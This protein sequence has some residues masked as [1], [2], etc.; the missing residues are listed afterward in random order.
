MGSNRGNVADERI[1]LAHGGG[2]EL[3]KRLLAEHI[4]PK[5]GNDL[6]DPLTDAAVLPFPG[7]RLCL[8]TDA[9]VVQP[10][11]F[12]GGD[13]GTLAVCGTVNDL[14]MMGATPLALSLAIVLDEGLPLA[15]LDRVI[16]SVAAEAGRADVR[17]ATG[18]TKVLERRSQAE[19]GMTITTAGVGALAQGVDL[20]AARVEPG[21]VLI[22][23]GGIAEHGLAVLSAR[24][25]LSFET[26]LRSD[27]ASLHGLVAELLRSEVDVKFLRDPTRGGLAGLLADLA[28]EAGCGVEIEEADVPI[29]PVVLH[30]AEMLG[31]DP[32][33]V[34]NEGKL[35]AVVPV[36]KVEKALATLRA[37]PLGRR[38]AVIGR[39]VSADP[40][41]VELQTRAGGRRIVQR[42]YGEELP[43]IC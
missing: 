42:P 15:T 38:A 34:A 24:E 8:T 39:C 43:R 10:L 22:V 26:D 3:M 20:R 18:D 31:L 7:R 23:S 1:L 14:A 9:F 28:E 27:A 2:G 6:L 19:P 12:P 11:V 33:T 16:A 5:L 21:D 4:L 13:I 30:T 36:E 41:L 29:L 32:L 17:I 25:G 37:H 35:V 40:P